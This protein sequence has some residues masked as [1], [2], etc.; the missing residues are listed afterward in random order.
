MRGH[1]ALW[2]SCLIHKADQRG[3][4]QEEPGKTW[5]MLEDCWGF[6]DRQQE[7]QPLRYT[8]KTPEKPQKYPIL[9]FIFLVFFCC[10][11]FLLLLLHLLLLHFFMVIGSTDWKAL[12]A[13][14]EAAIPRQSKTSGLSPIPIQ[15]LHPLTLHEGEGAVVVLQVAL[16]SGQGGLPPVL[17]GDHGCLG[18]H[19][20]LQRQRLQIVES[21]ACQWCLYEV[22]PGAPLARCL[23]HRRVGGTPGHLRAKLLVRRLRLGGLRG[24]KSAVFWLHVRAC[25]AHLQW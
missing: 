16:L 20:V 5:G 19:R 25:A 23:A 18:E 14:V 1:A 15:R 6:F 17:R 10:F 13:V 12:A 3:V 7:K 9:T 8:N 22:L 21:R 24:R 11:A 4:W 2:L